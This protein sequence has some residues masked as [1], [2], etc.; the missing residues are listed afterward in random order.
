VVAS[1]VAVVVLPRA[2]K[3]NQNYIKFIKESPDFPPTLHRTAV[4][5][6]HLSI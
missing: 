6:V 2:P 1:V 4:P 5:Y 3:W